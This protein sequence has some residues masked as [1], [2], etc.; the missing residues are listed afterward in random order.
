[1]DLFVQAAFFAAL[2][3][4]LVDLVRNSFDPDANWNRVVWQ[5]LAF[6][7]GV[8]LAFIFGLNALVAFGSNDVQ[9]WAG[10]LITGLALGAGSSGFHELFDALSS[11]AKASRAKAAA[12]IGTASSN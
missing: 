7:L 11:T 12:T 2:V 5:V 4:K 6:G 1:M 3:T 8:A 10:E 9:K